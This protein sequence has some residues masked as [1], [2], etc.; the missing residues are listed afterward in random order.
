MENKPTQQTADDK[1]I[2]I[3]AFLQG[4]ANSA[5]AALDCFELDC[6]IEDVEESMAERNLEFCPT[7]GWWVDSYELLDDMD[8]PTE[9]CTNCRN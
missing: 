2:E 1:W 4:T 5:Q 7:C 3:H 9:T 8:E 6:D